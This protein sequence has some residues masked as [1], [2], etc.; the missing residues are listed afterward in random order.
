VVVKC[1]RLTII[2]E[3]TDAVPFFVLL[4][5]WLNRLQN[6]QTE[7][8]MFVSLNPHTI[9]DPSLT[10]HQVIMAHPQFTVKTLAARKQLARLQGQD[11][12]WYEK[13]CC[14]FSGRD[15]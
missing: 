3:K 13:D 8:N 10:H 15:T 14:F 5:S 6:L 12:L 7:T 1:G 4:N 11:G 2:P 9:P